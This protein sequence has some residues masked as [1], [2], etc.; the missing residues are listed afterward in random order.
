MRIPR[1]LCAEELIETE[2]GAVTAET[3]VRGPFIDLPNP[4]PGIVGLMNFKPDT[5]AKLTAFVQQIL[6]GPS[7]LTPGEREV[8]AALV[9]SRN[10]TY[11]CAHTHAAVA[12]HLIEGGSGSIGQTVDS[13]DA[14]PVSDKMRALLGIAEKV[15]RSGLDVTQ[16]DIDGAR[17][18]GATDE[19][20][21]DTV[22]VASAF[23]LF[24]RYV[25]GLAA[26]TPRD[27]AIY[28]G[29]GQ[30]LAAQGYDFQR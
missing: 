6:R 26:I 7:S 9:S 20:I 24:N 19:D 14:A 4:M 18:V 5:G 21:H 25:D 1:V 3:E 22:L 29:I 12:R 28:D 11:F 30:M 15:T 10:N 16:A 13:I 17:T 23:C 8:I 2:G 27:D